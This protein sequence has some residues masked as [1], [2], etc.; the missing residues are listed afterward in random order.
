MR[1]FTKEWYD[2][3]QVS[4]YLAYHE[5]LEEWE[6]ELVSYREE[7]IDYEENYRRNLENM[8][9]DL[10]KFLPEPFHPYIYNG[11][12]SHGFPPQELREMA[13]Q[14]E[15]EHEARLETI[16]EDYSKHYQSIKDQLPVGAV[17][18]MEQS[19]HDATVIS[20]DKETEETLIIKLDCSKGFHYFTDIQLTFTGVTKA[21]IPENFS[22]ARWL[23]NEI[24]LNE[25]RFELH[26][27]FDSPMVEVEIVAQDVKIEVI[28]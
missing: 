28:G 21:E 5:S 8:R 15:Q 18:L 11:T 25:D 17:Q 6:E 22:G 1:Y 14:W 23:Y 26:V 3:M 16:N 4:G 27:L 10:L 2:E 12:I 24:Y 7:G 19:L 9:E 20:V 13:K